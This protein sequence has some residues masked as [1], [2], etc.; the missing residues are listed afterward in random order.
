MHFGID[1][2]FSILN[3]IWPHDTNEQGEQFLRDTT[4][5]CNEHQQMTVAHLHIRASVPLC[6]LFVNHRV[7]VDF[8]FPK[9]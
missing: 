1:N 9:V 3:K 7:A 6:N 8:L 4:K 5:A 2:L